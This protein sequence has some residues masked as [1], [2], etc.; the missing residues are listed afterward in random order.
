M[1]TMHL[2]IGQWM[3]ICIWPLPGTKNWALFSYQLSDVIPH[4]AQRNERHEK[5]CLVG[6]VKHKS[7]R[8]QP[9]IGVIDLVKPIHFWLSLPK[10]NFSSYSCYSILNPDAG[11]CRPRDRC[12]VSSFSPCNRVC[13]YRKPNM[14]K[15]SWHPQLL[16]ASYAPSR[17]T[18]WKRCSTIL[19][20]NRS[21]LALLSTPTIRISYA[22]VSITY[23]LLLTNSILHHF[24]TKMYSSWLY[25]QPRPA[26]E[27]KSIG[28]DK[29]L[30]EA[31]KWFQWPMTEE[32][33]S[34][35]VTC[36]RIWMST[37]RR[38]WNP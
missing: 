8:P 35:A 12:A 17:Y 14:K 20:R 16:L 28:N 19:R 2:H 1:S 29:L 25:C 31:R 4:S 9:C 30:N 23:S 32:Q 11:S 5:F 24:C 22:S 26:N 36:F 37:L 34:D 13:M 33:T 6:Q 21:A 27:W 18:F 7:A 10:V 15:L 3:R 38:C